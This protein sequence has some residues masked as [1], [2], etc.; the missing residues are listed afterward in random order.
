MAVIT[1][2]ANAIRARLMGDG[3]T[4]EVKLRVH[5][6]LSYF[7]EGAEHTPRFK[8]GAWDGRASFFRFV[9][10]TFPAG[11]VNAVYADLTG[12]GH[13]V[14]LRRKRPPEPL[15][16]PIDAAYADVTRA[17]FGTDVDPAYAF[18]PNTVRQLEKHG[19]IIAQV[20]TGGGKSLIAMTAVRRIMRPTLFLTTRTVLMHQMRRG[21]EGAG[22]RVGVMG[23]SEWAPVKG[24]NV[25]TIQTIAQRLARDDASGDRTR[26]LLQLFEFAI[27]EEA[28][29][30]GGTGYFEVLNAMP[31]ALYRLALTA[32]PFMRPDAEANMRLMAVSGQIGMRV[33]ERELI[34]KGILATPYFRYIE[35]PPRE[36]LHKHTS[37]QNAYKLGVVEHQ[38][39]NEIIVDEV[40]KAAGRGLTAMVL[41]QRRDHGRKLRDMLRGRGISVDFIFGEHD[42]D[43]RETALSRLARGDLQVLIGS[44][45]L[46]VGV[47]VPAVGM[48]VL[49]G[50]GKAEVALRQRIGRGLRAKKNGPNVCYVLDFIDGQNKYLAEHARTRRAIVESTPG[51]AENVLPEG[52]SFPIAA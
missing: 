3:A 46:D 22:F 10:S 51:F 42:Q 1:I 43:R 41:V 34:D 40:A 32:T 27:L 9:D 18:Q 38:A 28:H 20:A 50:A 36:K 29:E 12:Q 11:F 49:A 5:D 8:R 19:A 47:D 4:R 31:N 30:A 16:L 15:G 24:V 37:W 25:A 21:F 23:D 2:A 48:V 13:R 52:A 39:R 35:T 6:L 17:M 14:I 7:I 26:K 45:I 44:T 33:T